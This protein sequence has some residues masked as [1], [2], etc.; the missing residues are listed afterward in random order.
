MPPY[1]WEFSMQ[2]RYIFAWYA[3]VKL[4]IAASFGDPISVRLIEYLTRER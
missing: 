1:I 4:L 3:A 2:L